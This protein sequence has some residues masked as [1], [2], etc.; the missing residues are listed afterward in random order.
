MVKKLPKIHTFRPAKKLGLIVS[1]C[2]FKRTISTV[3]LSE[4]LSDTYS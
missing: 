4:Y 3:D 2:P 1:V